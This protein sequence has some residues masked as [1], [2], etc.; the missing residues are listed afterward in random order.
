MDL[1]KKY[2]RITAVTV[3]QLC[4]K[5]IISNANQSKLY[6]W[7]VAPTTNIGL[8][9]WRMKFFYE[10]FVQGSTLR[11]LKNFCIK[12]PPLRKTSNR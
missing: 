3:A 9:I 7:I 1:G 6:W 4:P 11:I 5:S 2:E 12:N 10:A 8:A